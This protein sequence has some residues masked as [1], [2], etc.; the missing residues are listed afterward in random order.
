MGSLAGAMPMN[1]SLKSP[2]APT[3]KLSYAQA[4]GASSFG[5][6][7]GAASGAATASTTA[8]EPDE[9]RHCLSPMSVID[10]L[11]IE[12]AQQQGGQLAAKPVKR[13]KPV[14]GITK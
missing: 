6:S 14:W 1:E 2:P 4:V 7:S 3:L 12:A 11:N 13:V 5:A 8:S 10:T 9:K